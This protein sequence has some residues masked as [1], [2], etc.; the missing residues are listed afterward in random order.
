MSNINLELSK[1]LFVPKFYPLLFDYSH[2]WECYMG[3]AGS[4]KSYFITQKLLVRACN[5]KINILVCRRFA[6]TI[7]NSTFKLFKKL[8]AKW[9]LEQFAKINESDYRIRLQNGS[10]IIFIGLDDETKLLSLD[11]IG[12]IFIEEAFEIPKDIA[13]QLNLR[14]RGENKNKQI[15]MAWNPI[16]KNCWLYDF[17]EVNPPKN[18][19]Y[20][21]STFRDNPFLDAEDVEVLEEMIIRNPQKARVFC[22]GLWGINTDGLVYKN[23]KVE[24]FDPLELSS[25]GY[26]HRVGMDIGFIDPSTIVCTLYDEINKTIYIYKDFSKKGC[27]LNK[28]V[29]QLDKFKL[30]RT[31]IYCDSA[32]PRAI[33]F[34][35]T[36][37]FNVYSSKKGAGS[38]DTGIAFIQNHKIIVHPDCKAVIEELENYSYIKDKQTNDFTNKTTH[39]FSHTLDGLRYAYC[40]LYTKH[41]IST[42]NKAIFGL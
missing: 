17:C 23:W 6:S 14:M 16:N 15:I 28:L 5:E 3:S 37:G 9:H 7:R 25:T 39:E 4:A 19:L 32:D 36:N 26:E 27:Q 40:D 20:T 31:K 38:V 22:F 41:K 21:H 2:R 29:V 11:N 35:R 10:E 42:L 34:F 13:D 12:S 8:I 24:E 30:H 33:S 18:F 1:K